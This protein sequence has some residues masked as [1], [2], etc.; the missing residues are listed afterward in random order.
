MINTTLHIQG[1]QVTL[2]KQRRQE[3]LITLTKG[4]ES[5]TTCWKTLSA[6]LHTLYLWKEETPLPTTVDFIGESDVVSLTL[7]E[8]QLLRIKKSDGN[9]LLME[10]T[11]FIFLVAQIALQILED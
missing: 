3:W 6:V 2:E 8:L 5:F 4:G 7:D 9:T 10:R 11:S 1:F